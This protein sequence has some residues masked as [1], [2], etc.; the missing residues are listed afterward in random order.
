MTTH[1]PQVKRS[2]HHGRDA[3]N[4]A[5]TKP[6]HCRRLEG[7]ALRNSLANPAC[8]RSWRGRGSK[9]SSGRPQTAVEAAHIVIEADAM[10]TADAA[11]HPARSTAV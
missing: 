4:L 9:G 1:L 7:G 10:I 8:A 5:P 11:D 2:Q 6:A 3:S